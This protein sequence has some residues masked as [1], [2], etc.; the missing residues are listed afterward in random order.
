MNAQA[1]EFGN[2]WSKTALSEQE[3]PGG[4]AGSGAERLGPGLDILR[5]SC[6]QDSLGQMFSSPWGAQEEI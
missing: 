6:L 4:E 2:P 1:S 3:T 5:L